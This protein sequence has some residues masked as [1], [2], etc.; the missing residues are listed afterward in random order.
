M[1]Q[2][3]TSKFDDFGRLLGTVGLDEFFARF[4]N[5]RPLH[6]SG[7]HDRFAGL[8]CRADFDA[9]LPRCQQLKAGFYDN[10]GWFCELA[11]TPAQVK[12]LW[13]A[14]MTICAGVLPAEGL[15][16]IPIAAYRAAVAFA[17]EVYFNAY[18]SPD[19]QGFGLHVDDHPVLVFQID[20]AKR[21]T[22]SPE[23][24]LRDPVRGF[25]F[26][27]DRSRLKTPWGVFERPDESSFLELLLEPGDL[28]YLPPGTW[29]KAKAVGYSLALTMASAAH[30][31]LALAQQSV[32]AALG[33]YPALHRRVWGV[34]ARSLTEESVPLEL[35]PLFAEAGAA[36]RDWAQGLDPATLYR[37]WLAGRNAGGSTAGGRAAQD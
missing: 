37:I 30:S 32:L 23:V 3:D 11:I 22:V 31:P 20:G 12:R 6:V 8:F 36:L 9:L 14:N 34:D 33:S 28:L 7:Q 2:T 26:P 10:R 1:A 5:Q 19:G 4:W 29:H 35:L 21:W 17:G 25:S 27:P 13:E 18:L 16:A 15:L 24:A